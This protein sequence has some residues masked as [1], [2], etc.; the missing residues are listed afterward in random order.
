MAA[1]GLRPLLCIWCYLRFSVVVAD[2]FQG[3]FRNQCAGGRVSMPCLL[4]RFVA[5]IEGLVA[6]LHLISNS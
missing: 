4:P 3:P 2:L 6:H 1:P 5:Y